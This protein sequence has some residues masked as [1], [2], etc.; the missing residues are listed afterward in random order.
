MGCF[1]ECKGSN[2]AIQGRRLTHVFPLWFMFIV[3]VLKLRTTSPL[4]MTAA[5][6]ALSGSKAATRT[7]R[8]SHPGAQDA[9]DPEEDAS[10]SLPHPS[11]SPALRTS[12]VG[13]SPPQP[14]FP[15][16]A[17]PIH[18]PPWL[19]LHHVPASPMGLICPVSAGHLSSALL[20]ACRCR[21][22]KAS[23]CQCR[24][25]LWSGRRPQIRHFLILSLFPKIINNQT[26]NCPMTRPHGLQLKSKGASV[27]WYKSLSSQ[28][29]Q[30][31]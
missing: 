9:E 23:E 24:L 5:S 10:V 14:A 16:P 27:H 6:W 29:E 12:A 26:S 20:C 21:G 18:A 28:P 30:I 11:S 31:K 22:E 19:L 7:Q 2:E 4:L 1:S 17:L 13:R 3:R 15:P 8:D 25:P